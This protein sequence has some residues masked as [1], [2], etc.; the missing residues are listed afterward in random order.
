[1]A[2]ADDGEGAHG[3]GRHTAHLGGHR[4][5]AEPVAGQVVEQAQVAHD[6]HTRREQDPQGGPGAF[7]GGCCAVHAHSI[8]TY[9]GGA[10]LDQQLGGGLLQVGVI[11][12]VVAVGAP[13]AVPSRA[14]Q[15]RA[16]APGQV[17]S[18]AGVGGGAA[19]GVH[20]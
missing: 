12:A 20:D 5:E 4:V 16:A 6:R 3:E 15:D 10:A 8:D 18:E 13:V 2:S 19:A 17:L 11:G 9:E 14:Q 1:R 7:G